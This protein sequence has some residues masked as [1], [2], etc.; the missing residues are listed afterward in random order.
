MAVCR[1]H[2][3]SLASVWLAVAGVAAAQNGSIF[4]EILSGNRVL[5]REILSARRPDEVPAG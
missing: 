2:R 3:L 5:T 4:P 1:A